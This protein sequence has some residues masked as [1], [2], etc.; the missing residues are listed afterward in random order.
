MIQKYSRHEWDSSLILK[1]SC[2]VIVSAMPIDFN[3]SK[4]NAGS[5]DDIRTGRSS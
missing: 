1:N 4:I 2:D 5:H 3:I